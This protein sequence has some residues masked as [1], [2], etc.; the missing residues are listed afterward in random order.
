[1]AWAALIPTAIGLG[2]SLLNSG[3]DEESSSNTVRQPPP[4]DPQMQQWMEQGYYPQLLNYFGVPQPRQGGTATTQATATDTTQA[5]AQSAQNNANY[6]R[7]VQ[8]Y[9]REHG[10]TEQEADRTIQGMIHGIQTGGRNYTYTNFGGWEGDSND[11]INYIN[12]NNGRAP[13]QRP[14]GYESGGGESSG[15]TDMGGGGGGGTG[16]GGATGGGGMADPGG[17]ASEMG[18]SDTPMKVIQA[19]PQISEE[20][21]Y[22]GDVPEGYNTGYTYT[23]E[24]ETAQTAATTEMT[25]PVNQ[26]QRSLDMALASTEFMADYEELRGRMDTLSG[27]VRDRTDRALSYIADQYNQ[28]SEGWTQISRDQANFLYQAERDYN[29]PVSIGLGGGQQLNVTSR[30]RGERI[31][32]TAAD[33]AQSQ[34]AGMQGRT[35]LLNTLGPAGL[36]TIMNEGQFQQN[37]IPQLLNTIDRQVQLQR[38]PWEG[39]SRPLMQS[40][41]DLERARLGAQGSS[42]TTN[43]TQ[44]QVDAAGIAQA[45]RDIYA[46]VNTTPTVQQPVATTSNYT[47]LTD[48]G[49]GASQQYKFAWPEQDNKIPY[50]MR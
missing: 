24:A 48:Q 5:N 50:W 19:P 34:A 25:D 11:L 12:N 13:L 3:N 45:G 15:G 30:A 40:A 23:G 41:L 46:A 6:N 42:S 37:F 21:T 49:Y 38:Y 47:P 32:N 43:T 18:G 33:L 2:A 29:R 39:V 35:N 16:A 8:N 31:R 4:R 7:A 9:A 14:R 1:M 36:Q 20:Q 17:N 26:F 28:L 10:I 22:Y 44:G 27:D